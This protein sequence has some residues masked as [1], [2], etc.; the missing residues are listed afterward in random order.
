M[1]SRCVRKGEPSRVFV[2]QEVSRGIPV[3]ELKIPQKVSAMV[4]E[5]TKSYG[6]HV[7]QCNSDID[8]EAL[9]EVLV[10]FQYREL[11]TISRFPIAS[12]SLSSSDQDPVRGPSLISTRLYW[13]GANPVRS[14]RV[15]QRSSK[16]RE[17]LPVHELVLEGLGLRICL[18]SGPN[19]SENRSKKESVQESVQRNVHLLVHLGCTK[20]GRGVRGKLG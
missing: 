15:Y 6:V 10:C 14:A 18:E 7:T 4:Q 19:Q 1:K 9:E 13:P 5:D 12:R 16:I 2:N 11:K 8:S 3:A 20:C 17:S